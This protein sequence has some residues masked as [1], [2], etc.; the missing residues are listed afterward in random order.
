MLNEQLMSSGL[1]FI[2]AKTHGGFTI[3]QVRKLDIKAYVKDHL[4]AS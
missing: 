4:V 3:T 2:I 1:S